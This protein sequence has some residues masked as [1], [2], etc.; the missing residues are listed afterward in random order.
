MS[1]AT[2]TSE[3]YSGRPRNRELPRTGA[4]IASTVPVSQIKGGLQTKATSIWPPASS[5]K[6]PPSTSR[7]APQASATNS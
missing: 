1:R 4:A 5:R 7:E 6:S 2:T 3:Q